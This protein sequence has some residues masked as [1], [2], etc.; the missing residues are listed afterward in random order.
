MEEAVGLMAA[1]AIRIKDQKGPEAAAHT[2]HIL[3]D[4]LIGMKHD[5]QRQ[6]VRITNEQAQIRRDG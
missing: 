4:I 2:L 3:I 1:A 6:A 5:F